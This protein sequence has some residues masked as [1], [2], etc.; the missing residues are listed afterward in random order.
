MLPAKVLAYNRTT[1]RAQLQIMVPM[2][3]TGNQVQQRA[4]I[5]SVPVMQLG[6]GGFVVSFPISVGDIGWI[7]ANDRDISIF[8]STLNNA[9]GPPT[10]R[11][12]KF[13]DA[14]FIPDTMFKDVDIAEEDVDNLV[15]QNL[16]GTVKIS[17]WSN[18]LKIIAPRVGIGGT[19]DPNAIL[20]VQS[21]TKA[22]IPPRMTI[23]Q[24]DAIPSPV[25]GMMVWVTDTQYL[26]MYNGLTEAWS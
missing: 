20:D 7:K 15:I 23:V 4:T 2:V 3:T 5:A 11:L 21:T 1:N 19:P 14:V 17:W 16:A 26:S 13:S 9:S 22:F 6:G 18:L 24:R 8:K 25:G 12:H 10:Q